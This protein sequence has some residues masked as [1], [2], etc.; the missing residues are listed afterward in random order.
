MITIY[1]PI[2]WQRQVLQ[3]L[4]KIKVIAAG[5]RTGKTTLAVNRLIFEALR[6]KNEFWYIS[7]S[8]KQSK[9]IAWQMLLE[10]LNELN[11]PYKKNEV[12]LSVKLNGIIKLK[13]ADNSDSL[14]GNKLGGLVIDEA[15]YIDNLEYT[16]NTVLNP[17]LLDLNGWTIF[18]STPC[19]FNHF[20][21]LYNKH[22]NFTA[23]TTDN[24]FISELVLK[25]MTHG[26]HPE[27]YKQEIEAAFIPQGSFQYFQNI[28]QVTLQGPMEPQQTSY[29]IG[30]DLGR[31]HDS[32]VLT[33]MSNDNVLHG[34]ESFTDT[35]WPMQKYR[36]ANFVRKYNSGRLVI[37]ATNNLSVAE[38]LKA[39]G[40]DVEAF[41]FTHQSKIELLEK[42]R[43]YI[44]NKYIQ[45][46]PIPKLI[47]ELNK[48][49][50][51]MDP[52]KLGTQTS[53]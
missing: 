11:I 47:E 28:E 16:Y 51:R 26:M 35:D 13:G 38:D 31:Y 15:A 40:L 2:N 3:N 45:I 53:H 7:P 1:E 30:C 24:P 27:Q 29:L 50:F 20:Y 17:Q 49:E 5:R 42:L 18:I 19:G 22:T 32:T 10:K 25:D 12:E 23:K 9:Q 36:I 39:E 41:I 44:Y 34:F 21:D 14:R 48:F 37:D 33:A 43:I 4:S 6:T 46:P 52:L 8:Y